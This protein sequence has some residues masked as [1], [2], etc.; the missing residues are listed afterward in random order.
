MTQDF[1]VEAL[2]YEMRQKTNFI[3]FNVTVSSGG[4]SQ[5]LKPIKHIFGEEYFADQACMFM[6][7]FEPDRVAL[8][9][10]WLKTVKEEYPK[11]F[12]SFKVEFET[13][14]WNLKFK[15]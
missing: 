4:K 3:F 5:A 11:V 10:K 2:G 6:L 1:S 14:I 9:P 15:T 12:Q 8:L 7:F 13:R